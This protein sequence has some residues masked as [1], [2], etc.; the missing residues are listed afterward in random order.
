MRMILS[1]V[2][3][4]HMAACMTDASAD[5]AGAED[6][7]AAVQAPT[8]ANAVGSGLRQEIYVLRAGQNGYD[9]FAALQAGQTP[10]SLGLQPAQGLTVLTPTL[11]D[12]ERKVLAQSAQATVDWDTPIAIGECIASAPQDTVH[13]SDRHNVCTWGSFLYTQFLDEE[14]TGAAEFKLELIG[15]AGYGSEFSSRHIHFTESISDVDF[16]AAFETE[17]ELWTNPDLRCIPVSGSNPCE[18]AESAFQR[19]TFSGWKLKTLNGPK[20]WTFSIHTSAGGG[21]APGDVSKAEFFGSFTIVAPPGQLPPVQSVSLD[22]INMRWDHASYLSGGME[23]DGAAIFDYIQ[24][25]VYHLTGQGVDEVAAHIKQA[26][27]EPGTTIPPDPDKF[28]PGGDP[29][30]PLHRL[31]R[32]YSLNN[33]FRYQFNRQDATRWCESPRPP[34]QQCDEF[35]FAATYE[36][37]A[38]WFY[39]GTSPRAFSAQLVNKEQNGIA[40]NIEQ[41]FFLNNRVLDPGYDGNFH[42]TELDSFYLKIEP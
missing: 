13:V 41:S 22:G 24:P 8:T 23:R 31:Y 37:A 14:P 15:R 30:H 40:G 16:I 20:T 26:L 35:P 17:A 2:L 3:G 29:Q 34:G 11:E 18:V 36:G 28:I 27:D 10:K 39:E 6:P 25:L 9:V 21:Q 12:F 42:P 33:N 5:L 32:H 19:D 38:K 1:M 4:I 7:E